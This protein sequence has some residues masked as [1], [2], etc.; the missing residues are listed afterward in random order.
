[1]N[2]KKLQYLW[3]SRRREAERDMQEELE[4]L[5]QFACNPR[6]WHPRR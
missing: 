5:A 6:A 2:W 1:M 4:S 3:P